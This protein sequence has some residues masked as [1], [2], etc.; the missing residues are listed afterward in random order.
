[1]QKEGEFNF[2]A[3][4]I[5]ALGHMVTDI[6]QGSLPAILPFLKDRLSLSYS[7]A[8]IIMLASNFTSSL[9]QPLFGFVS[10]REQRPLL[11]PVGCLFNAT[12]ERVLKYVC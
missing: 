2:R 5:L 4:L 12:T 10:D 3:L 7:M 6:Y 9:V 8:G 1:M 11:L